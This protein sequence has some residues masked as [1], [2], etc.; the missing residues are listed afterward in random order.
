MSIDG[1]VRYFKDHAQPI[2]DWSTGQL[3]RIYGA[4]QDITERKR[5]EDRLYLMQR[6]MDSSNNGIVITGLAE[7]D[8]AISYANDAFVRLTGYSLDK[9][10]GQNPR[11]LQ[12]NDR[13]QPN[14]ND[15][16]NALSNNQ[17]GY[18]ILRNSRQD[19]SMFWN[20]VYISPIKDQHVVITHY[21][22]I[23]NDV[24]NRIKMETS[25]ITSEERYRNLFENAV[26]AIYVN[27]GGNKIEQVN[28]ACLKL[29][30]ASD[31]QELLTKQPLDLFHPDYHDIIKKRL[32]EMAVNKV[33]L[34]FIE[35]KIFRLNGTIADVLVSA[36]PFEDEQGPLIYVKLLDITELKQTEVELQESNNKYQELSNRLELVR[37]EERTRIAREIHDALGS[38]LTVLKMDLNWMDKHL[39]HLQGENC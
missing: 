3:I 2:R 32:E 8:Y 26:E 34:P 18:T 1:D 23:Q 33:A 13:D 38:F 9:L 19:G 11:I 5:A 15:L 10:F 6:A 35:E 22:G 20:E 29:W 21:V 12:K 36:H 30:R 31:P 16:R 24:S 28:Q 25:L 14:L 17:D 7:T 27:R 37:E 39:P 4:I